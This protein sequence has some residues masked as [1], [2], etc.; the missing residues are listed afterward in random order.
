[1]TSDV[2]DAKARAASQ[3]TIANVSLTALALAVVVGGAALGLSG[4][5]ANRT[6]DTLQLAVVVAY[7]LITPVL[8]I[9]V[10]RNRQRSK[11]ASRLSVALLAIW[12]VALASSTFLHL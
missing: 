3:V 12:A 2:L 7:A 10:F 11:G 9:V 5:A 1:M 4:G 8:A 6:V